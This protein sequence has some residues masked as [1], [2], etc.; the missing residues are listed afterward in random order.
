MCGKRKRTGVKRTRPVLGPATRTLP[1]PRRPAREGP[2]A[3][4]HTHS[5]PAIPTPRAK[6]KVA[7]V[8]A[9]LPGV[10]SHTQCRD[11]TGRGISARRNPTSATRR[12]S[13]NGLCMRQLAPRVW[14]ARILP[15]AHHLPR[16]PPRGPPRA[17][18]LRAH[19]RV[20]ARL[21]P[22]CPTYWPPT[23]YRS[24]LSMTISQ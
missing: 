12:P 8:A 15:R 13:N 14:E 23:T 17:L 3:G 2:N 18:R 4:T 1:S 20:S 16:G 11:G 19:K 24:G 6:S 22:S 5:P 7:L 10:T 21:P 9:S